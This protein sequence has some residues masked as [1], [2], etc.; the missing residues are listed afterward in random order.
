MSKEK[1]EDGAIAEFLGGVLLILVPEP[2]T[3]LAGWG[4][5]VDGLRNYANA[6]RK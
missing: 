3:T 6:Q 4:M 1:E 5:V 2:S